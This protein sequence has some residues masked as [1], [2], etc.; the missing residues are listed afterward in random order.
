VLRPP[1][2]DA[3]KDRVPAVAKLVVKLTVP[4]GVPEAAVAVTL[5]VNVVA[6]LTLTVAV[7]AVS[8]WAVGVKAANRVARVSVNRANG[9][10]G[11]GRRVRKTL[12]KAMNAWV[13]KALSPAPPLG[14]LCMD[15]LLSKNRPFRG[16][17]TRQLP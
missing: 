1:A 14:M 15:C 9:R 13:R 11:R 2:Y 5:A 7:D 3:L 10:G 16:R 8:A 6:W 17:F 12:N 4:V